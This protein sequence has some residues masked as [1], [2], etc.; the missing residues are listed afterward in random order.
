MED[1][2]YIG[3]EELRGFVVHPIV[4]ESRLPL[5]ETLISKKAIE[6]SE[7]TQVYFKAR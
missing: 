1:A 5:I 3:K 2:I 6:H 4:V 7:T